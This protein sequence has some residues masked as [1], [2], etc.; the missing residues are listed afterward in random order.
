VGRDA[1]HKGWS[2]SARR[3]RRV[4]GARQAF[5][6]PELALRAPPS[7]RGLRRVHRPLD[8]LL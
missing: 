2:I 3:A 5:V 8:S 4:E 6:P 7:R 1:L